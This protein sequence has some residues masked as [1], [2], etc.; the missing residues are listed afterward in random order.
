MIDIGTP[1]AFT[2]EFAGIVFEQLSCV[3]IVHI[4]QNQKSWTQRTQWTQENKLFF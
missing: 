3:Q 1:K 2:I 4:V